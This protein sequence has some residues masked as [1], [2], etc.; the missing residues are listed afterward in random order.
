MAARLLREQGSGPTLLI[1]PLLALMRDQIQAARRLGVRAHTL[2]SSNR[3]DWREIQALLREDQIDVL[4]VSPE[5]LAND[6]FVQQ[7]LAPIAQRVALLVIDEAHCISDWGHDF[8]PDYQR[9]PRIVQALPGNIPLLATTATANTRVVNDIIAQIGPELAVSRGPLARHS[10]Q[11]QNIAMPSHAARMAW[12]A[13]RLPLL[14]GSGI[15]YTLTQYDAERA[16]EWLQACGINAR[17]YHGDTPNAEREKLESQLL[18]NEVKVLVATSALGMGFDKPDLG[19]V[20]HY[21]RPGSVVHYYQQV[22]RAGRALDQAYG[23]LLGGSDDVEITEY[24]IRTAFPPEAHVQEVLGALEQSEDGL[25]MEQLER[26]LN[27][28]RSQIDKVLKMLRAKPLAPVATRREQPGGTFWYLTPNRYLPDTEKI[29]RLMAIRRAEQQ[30]MLDYLQSTRCLMQFLAQELDDP[31]PLPCGRC[32]VCRGKVLL[33]TTFSPEIAARALAFLRRSDV[34]IKPKKQWKADSLSGY[35]WK[36]R[37]DPLLQASEGRALSL[38]GDEGWGKIVQRGKQAGHFD[39]VLIPPLVSLVRERWRPNPAPEWITYVPSNNDPEL[40]PD[41]AA[42]LAAAL[43]LPLSSCVRKVRDTDPQKA[44]QNSYQQAKNLDRV[45]EIDES[46]IQAGPVLLLDG[47]VNS[48]WTF[49]VVAALLQQSGSG[50][51]YP[52]ALANARTAEDA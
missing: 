24:F 44:M 32:A 13:E 27:L 2:N 1:S 17:P 8:R 20:I 46:M 4:I 34:L 28:S 31:D 11:L 30:R 41:L 23:V 40:L 6:T 42:Q 36:G 14:A 33:P 48:G 50:P 49:T 22:G 35:R 37:I 9:I 51:V 19:F 26:R 5:R 45:Y 7:E 25:S 12:L 21:Q 15:V 39:D 47:T 38:W 29:A 16:A 43:G 10:L 52:L 18:A 3:D